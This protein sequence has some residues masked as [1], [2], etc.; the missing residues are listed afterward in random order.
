MARKSD[1]PLVSLVLVAVLALLF[2][3]LVPARHADHHDSGTEAIVNVMTFNIRYDNPADGPNA[4]PL[5]KDLAARTILFH[6]AGIVG[7]QEA[8]RGQITD[9]ETLL[10]DYAWFGIGRDAGRDGGEFNPVFYRKDRYRVLTQSTFWLSATPEVAGSRGWDGACNR[11][12]TWAKFEDS[13][14]GVG[15]FV[16]NTHFDH[17]GLAAR[18]E[19]AGLL[20]R[21]IR[22]LAG[23]S[24]VIVTGD[25]N[26]SS[27]DEPYRLLTTGVDGGPALRDSRGLSRTGSY[28]GARSFN[29]F[30]E[31][32][33]PGTVIDHIFVLRAAGVLR[34][35][36]LADKWDGAFVSD[37]YPVLAGIAIAPKERKIPE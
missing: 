2:G 37:H 26:C 15:F 29:G 34:H 10:P 1:R 19:S 30:K 31:D 18:R 6:E 7:I 25:F 16:F 27:A 11:I 28:G 32:A 4:W 35:G 5:R 14:S 3:V 8:L 17:R 22:D 20:L 12:V 13:A 9:L 24:P 21:K 36:I 23:D 33:G